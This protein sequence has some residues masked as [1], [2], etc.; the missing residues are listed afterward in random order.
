M[1]F[2]LTPT[3]PLS[4]AAAATSSGPKSLLGSKAIEACGAGEGDDD[5]VVVVVVVAALRSTA[6]LFRLEQPPF[7]TANLGV[8]G[9][10][11]AEAVGTVCRAREEARLTTGVTVIGSSSPLVE[12]MG[13]GT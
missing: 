11:G 7:C 5:D 3:P 1:S 2:N 8:I 6:R 13:R 9:V 4:E 10:D 12:F